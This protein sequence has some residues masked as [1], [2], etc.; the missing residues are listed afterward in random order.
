MLAALPRPALADALTVTFPTLEADVQTEQIGEQDGQL[1]VPL[2]P[3]KLGVYQVE[4]N[5]LLVGHVDW[6]GQRRT[7]WFARSFEGGEPIW[8]SDGRTYHVAWSK[9]VS[10]D[11]DES[12]WADAVAPADDVLTLITCT[13]PFS[14]SRHM[15]LDRLLIRA[16]RDLP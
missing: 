10:V 6:A 11:A 7:L 15:Y 9:T 12:E 13:G 5:L 1:G 16:E 2:D 3:D 8:L 14:R 4:G